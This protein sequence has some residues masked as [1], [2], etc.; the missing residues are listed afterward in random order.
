M[1]NYDNNSNGYRQE[2]FISKSEHAC[3]NWNSSLKRG[4]ILSVLFV[5][6]G[7]QGIILATM[8]VALAAINAGFDTKVSEV[9]GMAQR[10]GSV[11]GSV[12]AGKKVFSPTIKRAD[13]L[14]AL[15]KLEGLRYLNM[16]SRGGY[17]I[18][19]DY[20]IYPSTV[21]SKG[22]TYPVDIEARVKSGAKNSFFINAVA[23]ARKLKEIRASN[24]VLTGV[25]SR[26]LPF[27]YDC[28]I[29]AIKE[30]VPQKAVRVNIEAFD[31]GRNHF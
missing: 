12:R 26:F 1:K 21:F 10:G 16:L 15:E 7:G 25:L 18:V 5:G 13:F 14:V 24:T 19:N 9:H 20:E 27:E 8:V 22:G 31:S 30:C 29:N 3:Q 11:I 17:A 2:A 28:W 4:D 6:V 23:V